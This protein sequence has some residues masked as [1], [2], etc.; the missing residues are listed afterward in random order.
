MTQLIPIT[1]D[2]IRLCQLLKL[3]GAAEGGAEAKAMIARSGRDVI[4]AHY[5]AS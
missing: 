5:A 3:A 2:T 4:D 1:G